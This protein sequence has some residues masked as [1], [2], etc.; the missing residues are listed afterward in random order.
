[1]PRRGLDT[2]Q[3]VREAAEILDAEGPEAL[4]LAHVADRLGVRS[5]SL[6]NHVAGLDDLRRR[7]G[8]HGIDLLAERCRSASMGRAGADAIAAIADAY[9]TMAKD[10]PGLYPLTQVATPE[11]EEWSRRSSAVLEPVLAALAG[12]GLEGD[13][14]IDAAR[15]IRAAIHGFVDLEIRGGFGLQRSVD[16]SF[17]AMIEVLVGGLVSRTRE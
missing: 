17:T 13:D 12:L 1:M 7:L 10:H 4:T 2:E 15:S 11:D 16:D 5:P 9:R 3:V 8:L 14:A 6:Y